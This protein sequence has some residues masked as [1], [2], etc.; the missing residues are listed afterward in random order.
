M[1]PIFPDP[2]IEKAD[3]IRGAPNTMKIADGR[4]LRDLSTANYA[5]CNRVHMGFGSFP[6]LQ[7]RNRAFMERNHA[8]NKA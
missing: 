3:V 7:F 4:R 8:G 6:E 2:E 5:A 1:I